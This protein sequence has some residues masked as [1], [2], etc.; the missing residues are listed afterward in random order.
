MFV[1]Y[2]LVLIICT[3]LLSAFSGMATGSYGNDP[4]VIH[5]PIV[6]I[7]GHW[8]FEGSL[9]VYNK[10]DGYVQLPDEFR[11]NVQSF[12]SGIDVCFIK[13][14][15]REQYQIKAGDYHKNYAALTNFGQ[16]MDGLYAGSCSDA[17]C[18]VSN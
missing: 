5:D 9:Y 8:D 11:N 18:P 2:S 17:I 10:T 13:W 7:Y 16:R 15:P 6:K 4:S 3:L 12:Q 14:Y 1:K